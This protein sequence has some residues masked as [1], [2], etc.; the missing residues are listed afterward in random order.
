MSDRFVLD[1]SVALAWCFQDEATPFTRALLDQ[2]LDGAVV[3]TPSIWPLEVS[4]G[5]RIAERRG[6]IGVAEGDR[7]MDFVRHLSIRVKRTRTVEIF[8]DVAD[9]ARYERLTVYDASYLYLARSEGLPLASLD[10]PLCAAAR[11]QGVDVLH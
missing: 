6:R 2:V 10:G 4:N 11:R 8:G 3:T 9:L 5:V 1:A 7:L